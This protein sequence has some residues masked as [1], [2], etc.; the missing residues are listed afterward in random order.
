MPRRP[1]PKLATEDVPAL[2]EVERLAARCRILLPRLNSR[3]GQLPA[4]DSL[5][6]CVI[7]AVWSLSVRDDP[8]KTGVSRDA[9]WATATW[10]PH[11]H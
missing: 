3:A 7:D 5:P 11:R 9:D 1:A 8:V 10:W 2:S 6:L 4:Y